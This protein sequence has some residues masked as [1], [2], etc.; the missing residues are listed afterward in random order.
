MRPG[1]QS[2]RYGGSSSPDTALRALP[3][4]FFAPIDDE[5]EPAK[6]K[7]ANQQYGEKYPP[8]SRQF[9]LYKKR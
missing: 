3:L 4:L 7:A 9:L 6:G 8:A 1:R 5:G 2:G